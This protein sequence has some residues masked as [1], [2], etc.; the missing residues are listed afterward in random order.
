MI[1]EATGKKDNKKVS[2]LKLF[3]FNLL[4]VAIAFGGFVFCKHYSSDDFYCFYNQRGEA[5]AVT[6]YSYRVVLGAIY[7]VLNLIGFNVVKYQ[8]VMGICMLL[9]FSGA[10]TLTTMMISELVDTRDNTWIFAVNIGSLMLIINV[11]V[12]EWI[13]FALAYLQWGLS[14][15]FAVISA[16][17]IMKPG[18]K[19]YIFSMLCL[20]I[21]A[22]CYQNVL[23]T[24][25]FLVM[26][27]IYIKE[28]GCITKKS[29]IKTVQA[30]IASV[31]AI[32]VNV[33]LTKILIRFGFGGNAS[34]VYIEL[35]DYIKKLFMVLKDEILVL[36]NGKGLLPEYILI[37]FF[38]MYIVALSAYLISQREKK[39]I[40]FLIIIIGA[41]NLVRW[42]PL[43][44]QGN[45]YQP[46]R[47]LVPFMGN[48]VVLHFLLLSYIKNKRI[49]AI[50][51][52]SLI[53]LG[54]NFV[55]IQV[56]TIDCIKTVAIQENEMF[57]IKLYIEDYE[58]KNNIQINKVIIAGDEDPTYKYYSMLLNKKYNGEMATRSLLVSWSD[59]EILKFY[60]GRQ[61]E[62]I[63]KEKCDFQ[64]YFEKKDYSYFLPAS[65]IKFLDDGTAFI[66]VY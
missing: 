63:E 15:L 3:V 44:M 21:V 27:F 39:K 8:V 9:C 2:T 28:K 42:L 12:S 45:V 6:Y 65:Q 47:M 58:K 48:F 66:Y 32:M 34:R 60:T 59:L 24:Y 38:I 50:I 22:G 18:K 16:I 29:I 62:K 54:I 13:W 14:I 11:F 33:L 43:F 40:I 51:I 35:N 19:C 4:F 37:I 31:V 56:N 36:K 25:V 7:Y 61:F 30:A 5:Y 53:L 23:S 26:T 57:T 49:Y 20:I 46:A 41:G 17:F 64:N 52:M 55:G 10:V 1:R